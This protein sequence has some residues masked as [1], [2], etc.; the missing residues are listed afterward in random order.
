MIEPIKYHS[1]FKKDNYAK[2]AQFN[3]GND[4]I[5]RLFGKHTDKLHSTTYIFSDTETDKIIS[6]VS[7]CAGAI[8]MK[9]DKGLLALPA[10]ELKLFGVD[11]KYQQQ[12]FNS[13]DIKA[14]YSEFTFIWLINY[15]RK[16]IQPVLNVEYLI[17]HS[18]P[19]KKTLKFYEKMGM[20]YFTENEN[21][22]TSDF[23][24]GCIPM[25]LKI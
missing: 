18:V 21:V 15:I 16:V 14:K 24:N 19:N 8:Q 25:Y 11:K 2:M 22:H 4:D 5:N 13:E 6:F 3:C 20:N 10:V 12:Y 17:L 7:F 1:S 9:T 23:S